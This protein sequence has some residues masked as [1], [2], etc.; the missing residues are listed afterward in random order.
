MHHPSRA[1]L[2]HGRYR[3]GANEPIECPRASWVPLFAH[4]RF[5]HPA[6]SVA[7]VSVVL[8]AAGPS[9]HLLARLLN[10]ML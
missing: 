5:E 10:R 7:Q 2:H 9:Q 8:Y 3:K 1:A 6:E 4:D